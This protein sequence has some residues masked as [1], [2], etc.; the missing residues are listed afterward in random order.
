MA[1]LAMIEIFVHMAGGARNGRGPHGG[2]PWGRWQRRAA[3]GVLG[4][5]GS[6]RE[7]RKEPPRAGQGGLSEPNSCGLQRRGAG[8]RRGGFYS[9]KVGPGGMVHCFV[10]RKVP[11]ELNNSIVPYEH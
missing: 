2:A 4:P 11:Y 3:R 5:M 1:G 7:L 9:L 8:W 6:T 10:V